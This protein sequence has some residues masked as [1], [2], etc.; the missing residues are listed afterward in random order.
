[1]LFQQTK[2]NEDIVKGY[3]YEKGKYVIFTDK[4]FEKIKTEK[5]KNITLLQFVAG[6]VAA[7]LHQHN[8]KRAAKKQDFCGLD[9]KW[10]RGNLRGT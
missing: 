10:E 6:S 7:T 4:E 8:E 5:D 1:M 2:F 9:A 3:Q